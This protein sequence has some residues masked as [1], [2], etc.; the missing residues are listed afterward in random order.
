MQGTLSLK[1]PPKWL[2]RPTSHSFGFGGKLVTVANLPSAQGKN[3]SSV[4]HLRTVVTELDFV[5]RA[6]KLQGAIKDETLSAFAEAQCGD[7]QHI[8]G[9]E[10]WKALLS[11]FKANSRDE[12]VTFLGFSKSEI[13]VRVAEAIEELKMTTVETP[14]SLAEDSRLHEP[15][16]SFAE[17]ESQAFPPY[18]GDLEADDATSGP[19]AE[20]TP[21]EVSAS[22]G[23]DATSAARLADGESTTSASLFGDDNALGAM[24]TDA[25]DFFSTIGFG[26][27]DSGQLQ[28]VLV[29]HHNYGLDSSVA[30]TMGS[31]P[32]SVT[33]ESGKNNHFRIYPSDE[34]EIDQLITKALVLGDFESAVSLC[35]ST[36]RFADA[37]LLAVKGGSELL[38]RTQKAYFERRTTSIPYLRLFQSIVTDDLADI[39]QNAD[40]RDWQE[41][42]VVLC[43]F[44][45]QEEFPGLAEQ[46]GGRLEFQYTLLKSFDTP[47]A[48]TRA[49]EFRKEAMLTYLA[50]GRL[51]RLVNIWIDE[52]AEEEKLFAS[53]EKRSNGSRYSAHAYALQTFIE[54]VTVFR[55]AIKYSDTDLSQTTNEDASAKTYKLSALYDRYFEYADLLAS[56]GLLKEAVPFL[57][58]T[59]LDYSTFGKPASDLGEGRDRLLRAANDSSAPARTIETTSAPRVA[60]APAQPYG[61]LDHTSHAQ[62]RQPAA[63]SFVAQPPSVYPSFTAPSAPQTNP[64]GPVQAAQQMPYQPTESTY[65]AYAQPPS[66]T[67][68]PHLQARQLP[69]AA[70]SMQP[71]PSRF[72]GA[73]VP[74]AATPPPPKRQENG[75]WND[76]P[77]PPNKDRRTPANLALNKPAAITSPFPNAAPSTPGTAGFAPGGSP[78]TS[79]PPA[80]PPPPRP[81]SGQARAPPPAQSMRPQASLVGPYPAPRGPSPAPHPHSN[82]APPARLMSPPQGPPRQPT[83][84]QYGPPPSRGVV[85]GQTPPPGTFTRPPGL[86]GPPGPP[87]GHALGPAGPYARGTPP[88]GQPGQ[89]NRGPSPAVQPGAFGPPHGVARAG[90]PPQPHGGPPPP[91]A[92]PPPSGPSAA[93]MRMR[94]GPPPPKYREFE[95]PQ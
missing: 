18:S 33:S 55:S 95:L 92:A 39:V 8:P 81:G 31:R 26:Q 2:R 63:Q 53:D 56:Q 21:S 87:H 9:A 27:S 88:P 25:A 19:A 46:L 89:Y 14:K 91:G 78:Y 74:V 58:L 4:V 44:A 5:E 23:S 51:E 79:P 3:Q 16:V 86:A 28:Q 54:K 17:P 67:Q 11:L 59:P 77:P 30:A 66:L 15:V 48:L 65:G 32:S 34:S 20:K 94:E 40:L 24:Q 35:L 93:I 71:P 38:Q 47:D 69:V 70:S 10:G 85:P 84:S 52:L 61:Y 64:Y 62:Q 82:L 42:F 7:E 12:L 57:K 29:P 68:P 75:G 6:N 49:H 45:S 37:I 13:V 1:Q 76:A 72:N 90:P 36:D 83:P 73:P 80:I 43:T 60:P 22:A 50:A 41:I